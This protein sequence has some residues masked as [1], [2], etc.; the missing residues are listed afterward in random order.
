[1]LDPEADPESY[2]GYLEEPLATDRWGNEW[3][4]RA[5]SETREGKYDLWS[6]GPDGEEGTEDDITSW[7][8]SEEDEE[9]FGSPAGMPAG[10]P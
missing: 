9:G 2:T 7:A 4:Y 5:E 1:V 10:A 3:G 8:S 6:N